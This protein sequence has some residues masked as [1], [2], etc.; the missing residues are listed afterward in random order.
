MTTADQDYTTLLKRVQEADD[1]AMCEL[2]ERYGPA[3]HRTA[4]RLVGRPLQAQLDAGDLVQSVLI[5]LWLGIRTGK[6]LVPTAERLLALAKT[7]LRRQVARHWR[8]A[9]VELN[10]T[11]EGNLSETFLDQ[12]LFAPA[13]ETEPQRSRDFDDLME[14]LLNQLDV[15]D[16][17]LV[18]LR[19]QGC[20]TAEA[21]RCLR[22][23]PGYLRVRLSRLRKKFADFRQALATP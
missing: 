20:S 12:N 3:M 16:K 11:L 4:E 19:F 5:A 18:N 10:R 15:I 14:D 7:M 13:K 22:L 1:A 23:D 2:I 21:A 8:T 6:F 9:K 17:R